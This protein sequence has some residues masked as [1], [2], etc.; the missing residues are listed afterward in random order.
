MGLKL[1]HGLAG[2]YG[3]VDC[4]WHGERFSLASLMA[5]QARFSP[6]T[7]LWM[8]HSHDCGQ[9]GLDCIPGPEGRAS[10]G[11]SKI[12]MKRELALRELVRYI[13]GLKRHVQS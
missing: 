10:R 11:D 5:A 12:Q 1:I 8:F 3:F 13:M 9:G 2:N 4:G 7:S 6:K